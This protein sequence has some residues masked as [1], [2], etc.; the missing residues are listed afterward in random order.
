MFHADGMI[1]TL[2]RGDETFEGLTGTMWS[3][4]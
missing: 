2:G 3:I 1:D 4:H